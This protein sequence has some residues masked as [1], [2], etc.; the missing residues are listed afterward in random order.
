METAKVDGKQNC[1]SIEQSECGC[2]RS[3]V[4]VVEDPCQL[5]GIVTTPRSEWLV[6][7]SMSVAKTARTSMCKA[8]RG[9][10]TCV[11]QTDLRILDQLTIDSSIQRSTFDAH[12]SRNMPLPLPVVLHLFALPLVNLLS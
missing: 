1:E 12:H 7:A 6:T 4:L 2:N 10:R 9:E 5:H 11:K 8:I 3:T